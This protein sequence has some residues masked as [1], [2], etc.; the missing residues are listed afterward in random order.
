MITKQVLKQHTSFTASKCIQAKQHSFMNYLT[1]KIEQYSLLCSILSYS[2]ACIYLSLHLDIH[3]TLL[4][5]LNQ[6]SSPHCLDDRQRSPF[7]H[8]D[9]DVFEPRIRFFENGFPIRTFALAGV[10]EGEHYHVHGSVGGIAVSV[11]HNI[12]RFHR[13]KERE[14]GRITKNGGYIMKD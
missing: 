1:C 5:K 11:E 12:V 14:T 13:I 7:R 9:P 2:Y 3:R 6:L 10:E 8:P 4:Y